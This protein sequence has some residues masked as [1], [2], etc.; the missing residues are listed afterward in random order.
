MAASAQQPSP[1]LISAP[2]ALYL[3]PTGSAP[4]IVVCTSEQHTMAVTW[5]SNPVE[6]G[7]PVTDHARP[8]PIQVSLDCIAS[9]TPVG[10]GY[11]NADDLWQ[12]LQA[13]Q[14]TPALVDAITIGAWYTNMG[15]EAV[16]RKIDVKTANAVAFTITLKQIRIVRNKLTQVVRTAVPKGQPK[17]KAGAVMTFTLDEADDRGALEKIVDAVRK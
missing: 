14:G 4:A 11:T 2:L 8:E 6:Q 9:K 1:D 5:T 13:L 12:K 7:A 3:P 16:G 15:V 10:Q 17:K